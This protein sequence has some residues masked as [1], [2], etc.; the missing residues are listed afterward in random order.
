LAY[1]LNPLISIAGDSGTDKII[2]DLL[3]FY[4]DN[5]FGTKD[6]RKGQGQKRTEKENQ[7]E[8]EEKK[9]ILLT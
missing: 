8:R 5:P 6:G 9:F 7:D 3:G 2:R 4:Q 1:D